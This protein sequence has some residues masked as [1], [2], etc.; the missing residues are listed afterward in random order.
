VGRN[1]LRAALT[2][3]VL[4]A[5]VLLAGGLLD[6]S[7]GLAA[8]CFLLVAAWWL[9]YFAAQRTVPIA[10]GARP[11]TEVERPE[12][13][14]LVRE[15][16]SAAKVPVPRLLVCPWLQPNSFVIGCTSRTASLCMTDGMLTVLSCGE[17]RAVIGH[18]LAHVRRYDMVLSTFPALLAAM[19]LWLGWIP[20]LMPLVSSLAAAGLRLTVPATREYGA[21]ADGALMSG[22]A[23]ALASALRKI[24]MSA[25]QTP[26]P[27]S[28]A[29]AAAS[30]LLIV[31][32]FS[33]VG[34]E[35][36]FEIHPPVGERLRRLESLAGY[37]R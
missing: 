27:F 7:T 30:H 12:L 28:R 34:L 10:L 18:E 36:L 23:L 25:R 16:S 2:A 5:A 11:L 17:L 20:G 4:V 19:V 29:V 31:D 22:D 6:G 14:R 1:G 21:D 15:L 9:A 37:P 33:G 24:E 35:R 13:Y 3:G 32:P 8:A 26:V